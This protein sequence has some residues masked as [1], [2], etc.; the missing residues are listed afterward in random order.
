MS[1]TNKTLFKLDLQYLEIVNQSLFLFWNRQVLFPV[2]KNGPAILGNRERPYYT[3]I[4]LMMQDKLSN[5][6]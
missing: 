3:I 6:N 5:V 1:L 4:L 2:A